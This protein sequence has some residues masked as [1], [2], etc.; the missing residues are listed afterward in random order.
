MRGEGWVEL[1]ELLAWASRCGVLQRAGVR[2]GTEEGKFESV[3]IIISG[4]GRV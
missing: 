4:V 2:V 3:V 1:V